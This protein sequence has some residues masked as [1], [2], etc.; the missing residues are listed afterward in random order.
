MKKYLLKIR[1][2]IPRLSIFSVMFVSLD[3]GISMAMGYLMGRF[4]A[5]SK[6][7]IAGRSPSLSFKIRRYRVH[8]HHWLSACIALIIALHLNFYIISP[9]IFYGFL[10]GTIF[11]GV[12]SYSDWYKILYKDVGNYT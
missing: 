3:F 9:T 2:A 10:G 12:I 7:A 1:K 6:T 11:Q 4:F 8:I 5:G